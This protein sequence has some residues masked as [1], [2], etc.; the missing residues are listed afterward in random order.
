M[1][2]YPLCGEGSGVP[3]VS[4]SERLPRIYSAAA[5]RIGFCGCCVQ[6]R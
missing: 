3:G 2:L 6:F 4:M 5:L 1:R